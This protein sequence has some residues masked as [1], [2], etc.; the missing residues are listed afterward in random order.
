MFEANKKE[1]PKLPKPTLVNIKNQM[2]TAKG[3]ANKS[4]YSKALQVLRCRKMYDAQ[5]SNVLKHQ[6]NIDQV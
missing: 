2:K 3:M 6:F 4:P 1:G 5:L